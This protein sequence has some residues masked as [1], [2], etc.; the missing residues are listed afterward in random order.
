MATFRHRKDPRQADRLTVWL[1]ND[2]VYGR[3]GQVTVEGP[4]GQRMSMSA[5]AK[6]AGV[7]RRTVIDRIREGRPPEDWYYAGNLRLRGKTPKRIPVKYGKPLQ[8]VRGVD[9]MH[10][11]RTY[12]DKRKRHEAGANAVKRPR[13][14]A[15]AIKYAKQTVA[16]QARRKA[17]HA[18]RPAPPA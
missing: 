3:V 7:P 8:G 2:R 9:P 12:V 6:L 15:T 18:H 14:H 11:Q 16:R 17:A 10:E 4:N 13:H 1:P 5:A